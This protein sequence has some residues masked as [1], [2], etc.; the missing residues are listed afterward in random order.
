LGRVGESHAGA[1]KAAPGAV[2]DSDKNLIAA[3]T[4]YSEFAA[5]ALQKDE[6]TQYAQSIRDADRAL[7]AV[8]A[9]IK[10]LGEVVA[11]VKNYPPFPPGND[12]R[13]Q[14]INGINGLRQQLEAMVVPPVKGES[15][16]VFYPRESALPPLDALS[17]SDEEVL[18]YGAALKDVQG[19]VDAGM[20]ALHQQAQ[21]LPEKI[22]ADLPLYPVSEEAVGQL[23]HEVSARLANSSQALVVGQSGLSQ[24]GV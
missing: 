15:E 2:V 1:V 3:T 9:V 24:L 18:A 10:D 21:S 20:A 5:L 12:Q 13:M 16:A 14:Y 4:R 17:A 7:D 19:K 8:E 6:A 11:L 23:I 22:N